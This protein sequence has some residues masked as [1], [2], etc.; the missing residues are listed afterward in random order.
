MLD[1]AIL[2]VVSYLRVE[3]ET[4]VVTLSILIFLKVIISVG[5]DT[6]IL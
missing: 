6:C 1:D 4:L 5:L 2:S 3:N